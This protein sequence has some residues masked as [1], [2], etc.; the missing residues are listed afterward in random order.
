MPQAERLL[1]VWPHTGKRRPQS[2]AQMIANYVA[3]G[4]VAIRETSCRQPNANEV[5]L[6]YSLGEPIDD[7]VCARVAADAERRWETAPFGREH[8]IW[9]TQ[10]TLRIYGEP[11]HKH[12]HLAAIDHD[13]LLA[14]HFTRCV[15]RWGGRTDRWI[16]DPGAEDRGYGVKQPDALIFDPEPTYLEITGS[17]YTAE[18]I[19]ALL[20]HFRDRGAKGVF[21]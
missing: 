19:R 20:E 11:D 5:L 8:F 7:M 14:E 1:A 15:V 9:A 13:W 3:A 16:C 6:I 17:R 10:K 2:A 18:R 21:V 4:F 12:V